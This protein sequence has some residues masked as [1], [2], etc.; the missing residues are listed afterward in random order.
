VSGRA[1]AHRAR[2]VGRERGRADAPSNAP[3]RWVRGCV[4]CPGYVAQH[5][6][7]A[8]AP[9]RVLR[10]RAPRRER[11]E[12]RAR[13]RGPEVALARTWSRRAPSALRAL[14]TWASSRARTRAARGARAVVGTAAAMLLRTRGGAGCACASA[15]GSARVRRGSGGG[16]GRAAARSP[17]ARGAGATP[18]SARAARGRGAA[19]GGLSEPARARPRRCAGE[20]PAPAAGA[21]SARDAKAIPRRACGAEDVEGAERGGSSGVFSLG[22]PPARGRRP[23]PRWG[24]PRDPVFHVEHGAGPGRPG[25]GLEVRSSRGRAAARS[26]PTPEAPSRGAGSTPCSPRA[27]RRRGTAGGGLS[28]PAQARQ[29]HCAGEFPTP[30]A[31]AGSA[32]DRRP[33][34]AELAAPKASR[35]RSAE[36]RAVSSALPPPARRSGSASAAGNPARSRVPRGTRR[37]TRPP[38][39]RTWARSPGV[40]ELEPQRGA[41]RRRRRRREAPARRR[42]LRARLAGG[43]LRAGGCP[44][45]RRR[46]SATA[47]ASSRRPPL[48]RDPR[49]TE[50]HASPS[51]R[52]RRRRGGGARRLERCLRPGPPASAGPASLS[53]VG[54]PGRSQCSTWNTEGPGQP[55]TFHV[56]QGP[57]GPGRGRSTWNAAVRSIGQIPAV[58]GGRSRVE[59]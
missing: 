53:A 17:P 6:A 1:R 37:T 58:L 33:C 42:G 14:R 54:I 15:A 41:P 24:I 29:R 9:S 52:R 2:G 40:P 56:E 46:V 19:G 3:R 28:E 7:Q 23:R 38:A 18:R 35:G 32:R 30:A 55:R 45:Q 21:G 13:L 12:R 4:G 5:P 11:S 43:E 36:A 50:G 57:G 34:L 51:L 39:A 49:A 27:A 44:S 25:R 10:S 48:G 16:R 20:P 31:G 26:P 47:L 59:A 22:H 8:W